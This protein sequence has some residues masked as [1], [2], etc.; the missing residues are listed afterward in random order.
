MKKKNERK[1]SNVRNKKLSKGSLS[2]LGKAVAG[3]VATT[4]IIMI[5]CQI[6]S[7]KTYPASRTEFLMDTI[8][9]VTI[10]NERNCDTV[11]DGV[12]AVC[13]ECEA[14][15][16]ISVSTSDIYRVNHAEGKPTQVSAETAALLTRANGYAAASG[17]LFDVTIQPVKELWHFDG[18]D[19]AIPD[20]GQLAKAVQ[21]VDYTRMVVN[22]TTVTLPKGMAIDLG[23]IAKG[24]A[25]DRMAQYLRERGI[26][27]AMI[28]LGGNILAIG[29]RPEGGNWRVGIQ[30]PFE[31]SIIDT[32]MVSDQAVVTSGVYQRYFEKDG[33]LYHHILDP[34]SGMP[35]DT[36]LFSVTMIGAS[37]EECDALST[38]GI[39]LG[40][41][42]TAELLTRYPDVNAVL[43][44]SHGEICR[45][46]TKTE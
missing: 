37:A 43:V 8:C 44:T 11:L 32:V 20:A 25:A 3:L 24:Y 15:L 23:A 38:V 17:G 16:S 28:D 33:I 22:G 30:K 18:S 7:Q 12:F 31:N 13:Q 6:V 4:A 27:S 35:C 29:H 39:L 45:I 36:G 2:T 5:F 46:G 34:H 42:K 26:K 21:K 9:T 41:Q 14:Q 19:D 1:R 10:F 40:Y